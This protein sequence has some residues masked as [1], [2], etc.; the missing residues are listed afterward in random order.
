MSSGASHH[1]FF[2]RVLALTLAVCV[3][4]AAISYWTTRQEG[5]KAGAPATARGVFGSY[6]PATGSSARM[7]IPETIAELK[8]LNVDTYYYLVGDPSFVSRGV[9][10]ASRIS[11]QAWMNCR[12]SREQRGQRG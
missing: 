4:V 10:D 1:R 2:W 5:T 9:A 8:R 3:L 7:D 6:V 12:L 11:R